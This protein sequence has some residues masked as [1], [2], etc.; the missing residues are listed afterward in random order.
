[1]ADY[2]SI[3]KEEKK[4]DEE[5]TKPKKFPWF[6]IDLLCIILVTIIGYIFYFINILNP[7]QI[8]FDDL[9]K[10]TT[11][12]QDLFTPLLLNNLSSS[13]NL[14]GIIQVNDTSYNYNLN[15]NDINFNTT[16]KKENEYLIFSQSQN[17]TYLKLSNFKEEY[18]EFNN[19]NNYPS[20]IKNIKNNLATYL[21]EDKFIKR[22]YLDGSNPI[23]AS[24]LSLNNE[25][26]KQLTGLTTIKNSYEVLLTLKN[27][28]ITNNIISIKATI[29]NKTTNKR[30]VI[31]YENGILNYK[32]SNNNL[33]FKLEKSN[34][35]DFELKIYKEDTLY[36]VLKGSEEGKKYNYSY[37]VIDKIYN[38][39]LE[40]AQ[41]KELINYTLNTI[42]EKDE[43]TINN[44]LS[45][46]INTAPSTIGETIN[47]DKSLAFD[48]LT[49]EDKELYQTS[50]DT[51]LID[52]N[53]LFPNYK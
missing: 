40:I 9:T 1:M 51:F 39:N 2:D 29:N 38:I 20:I 11:R 27:H 50:L 21:T 10:I 37:K 25:D 23:V 44:T 6:K 13:T 49:K 28:A 33:D 47:I 14:E 52:F 34:S 24:E 8:F 46:S 16:L 12:Y 15:K 22:Y 5:P 35:K 17:A 7:R 36:S 26:L 4:Y 41:E 42:V 30:V 19:I 48:T 3:L 53:N 18:L 32:D 31:T 45:L 43:K